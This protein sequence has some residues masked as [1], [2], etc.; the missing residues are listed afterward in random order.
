MADITRLCTPQSMHE[1]PKEME[2]LDHVNARVCVKHVR[3]GPGIITSHE[4]PQKCTHSRPVQPMMSWVHFHSY[5]ECRIRSKDKVLNKIKN[6]AT[7]PSPL[8]TVRCKSLV[9]IPEVMPG[10]PVFSDN[11]RDHN[12]YFLTKP[13]RLRAKEERST[14]AKV[15]LPPRDQKILLPVASISREQK[16][17]LWEHNSTFLSRDNAAK[18]HSKKK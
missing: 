13:V 18:N 8:Y 15:S 3:K 12:S 1:C 10:S 16:T 2:T 5:Y 11:S 9:N 14:A 6:I 17:K 4:P 7:T